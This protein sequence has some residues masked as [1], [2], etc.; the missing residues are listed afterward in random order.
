MTNPNLDFQNFLLNFI[1]SQ[2]CNILHINYQ[3]SMPFYLFNS[4]CTYCNS[5]LQQNISIN[6]SYITYSTLTDFVVFFEIPFIPNTQL[7]IYRLLMDL[8]MHNIN[9]RGCLTC[10]WLGFITTMPVGVISLALYLCV[11]ASLSPFQLLLFIQFVWRDSVAA[12]ALA[13]QTYRTVA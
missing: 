12:A 7:V 11:R 9:L 3:E 4:S 5:Q 6:K 1:I 13:W 2:C 10:L 8:S